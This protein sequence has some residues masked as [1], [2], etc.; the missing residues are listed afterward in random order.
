MTDLALWLVGVGLLFAAGITGT[1]ADTLLAAGVLA[2][3]LLH[4]RWTREVN[5]D[6]AAEIRGNLEVTRR[7]AQWMQ[8]IGRRTGQMKHDSWVCPHCLQ[9]EVGW[10]EVCGRCG[11]PN[12]HDHVR[13]LG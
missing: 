5:F 7:A 6:L 8:T 3:F 2:L 13:R 10:V 1:T 4:A 12:D 9:A 11:H